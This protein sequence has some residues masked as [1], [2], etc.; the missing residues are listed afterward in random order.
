M[1]RPITNAKKKRPQNYDQYQE[2]ISR[3]QNNIIYWF[4]SKHEIIPK[5]SQD[6]SGFGFI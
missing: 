4:Q 1:K 5:R 2:C 6:F 3:S